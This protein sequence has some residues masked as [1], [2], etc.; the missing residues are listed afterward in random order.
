MKLS[1]RTIHEGELLL[2]AQQ[3]DAALALAQFTA[4][5]AA[6]PY[7]PEAHFY[8]AIAL[9]MLERF[10]DAH[11]AA[12]QVLDL[13]AGVARVHALVSMAAFHAGDIEAAWEHAIRNQQ[14][15]G[16]ASGLFEVLLRYSLPPDDMSARLAAPMVFV[17]TEPVPDLMLENASSIL[18]RGLR[19]ALL[20]SVAIGVV[21]DARLAGYRLLVRVDDLTP[22]VPR[23]L[24]ATLELTQRRTERFLTTDT[25]VFRRS[26]TLS[27]IDNAAALRTDL[28]P[29]V[30][31]LIK[32]L[33]ESVDSK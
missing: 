7:Y 31:D 23:R 29:H 24:K 10:G 22:R 21:T 8:R 26:V 25:R 12:L 19:S 11:E 20:Q 13:E 15:G 33:L 5:A 2:Q 16:D 14:A 1:W 3:F 27:D 30:R 4:A 6:D 32:E 28:A 17:D 18:A 9:G